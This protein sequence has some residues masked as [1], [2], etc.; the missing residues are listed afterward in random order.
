[1]WGRACGDYQ[2]Q[3]LASAA[4]ANRSTPFERHQGAQAIAEHRERQVQLVAKCGVERVH[5]LAG[6]RWGWLASPDEPAWRLDRADIDGRWEGLEP[7][8]EDRC[9]GPR[10]RKT[11]EPHSRALR[12]AVAHEPAFGRRQ[13]GH[14]VALAQLGSRSKHIFA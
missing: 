14:S 10:M 13:I 12:I 9:A 7:A 4:P 6:G 3:W 5:E 8:S 2:S 11:E 1:M